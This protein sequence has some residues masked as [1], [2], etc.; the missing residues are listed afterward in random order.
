MAC[1]RLALVAVCMCVCASA[2]ARVRK[3]VLEFGPQG[4]HLVSP[5]FVVSLWLAC[6]S[7]A[8]TKCAWLAPLRAKSYEA[9]WLSTSRGLSQPRIAW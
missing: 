4:C 5:N 8:W 3:R 1:K 6:T 7:V 9:H 2:P